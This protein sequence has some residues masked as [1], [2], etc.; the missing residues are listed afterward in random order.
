MNNKY[1]ML[2]NNHNVNLA[3]EPNAVVIESASEIFYN[4]QTIL[5][6]R[7]NNTLRHKSEE[8]LHALGVTMVESFSE[9]ERFDDDFQS[10]YVND[11]VELYNRN[12]SFM[13]TI[14]DDKGIDNPNILDP[15]FM[16]LKPK[17]ISAADKFISVADPFYEQD[18][19]KSKLELGNK[20]KKLHAE[21]K[22]LVSIAKDL[23]NPHLS[24]DMNNQNR[25]FANKIFS[26]RR[27][28][29]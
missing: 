23:V 11:A 21:K 3:L 27:G 24:R 5:R 16:G 4:E 28:N 15:G 26:L 25:Y 14:D 7:G 10:A 9:S 2:I 8:I 18:E 29:R 1:K 13:D 6:M 22:P 20:F 12:F 19:E 17:L